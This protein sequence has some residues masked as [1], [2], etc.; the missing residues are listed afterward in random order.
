ME[1]LTRIVMATILLST[2]VASG[3]AQTSSK[4]F[5]IDQSKPYGYLKF[6]HVGERRPVKEGE[7]SKG[8][9]L[10]LVNNCYL[11]ITIRTFG[12]DDLQVGVDFEVVRAP[13]HVLSKDEPTGVPPVGYRTENPDIKTIS[14]KKDFLFSVPVNSV[15]KAW[16]IQVRFDLGLTAPSR[17][18]YHPYSLADFTWYDI[19]ETDRS[20]SQ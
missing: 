12:T 11:P 19:P 20:H 15:T 13:L 4:Q 5:V 18:A 7:S 9:W 1:T 3:F 16:Y 10:R 14:P 2:L 6:D 8:L 17:G